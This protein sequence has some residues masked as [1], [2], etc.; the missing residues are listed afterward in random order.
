MQRE[1][2]HQGLVLELVTSYANVPAGTWATVDSTGN[3]HDGAWCFTVRWRPYT[4]IPKE[5][6]RHV[7]EYSI[8]LWESDLALFEVLTIQD[9]QAARRPH[10]NYQSSLR[11]RLQQL[12]LQFN[13]D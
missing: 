7:T 6:P 1:N 5:F 2:V 12:S 3:M 8:N 11:P 13:D 10:P 9:E 4:P